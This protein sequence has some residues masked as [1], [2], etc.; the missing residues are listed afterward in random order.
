MSAGGSKLDW[1]RAVMGLVFGVL[2]FIISRHLAAQAALPPWF[3]FPAGMLVFFAAPLSWSIW[4]SY[5][6]FKSVGS[7]ASRILHSV[8]YVSAMPAGFGLVAVITAML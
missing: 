5:K 8:T 6:A 3:L 1:R 2:H 7:P 4:S